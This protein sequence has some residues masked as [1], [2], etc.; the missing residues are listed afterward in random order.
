M[1]YFYSKYLIVAVLFCTAVGC[2]ITSHS[3]NYQTLLDSKLSPEELGKAKFIYGD[4]GGLYPHTLKTNG[5]VYKITFLALAALD[6]N[7]QSITSQS[8]FSKYGFIFPKKI[9][10]WENG[11]VMKDKP[12]GIVFGKISGTLLLHGKY[13]IE[14]ADFG[15][16]SC[17]GGLTYDKEGNRTDEFVLGMPNTSLDLDK[18]ANNVFE[19]YK[20]I[21]KW[22]DEKFKK[23][24]TE[25]FPDI[26]KQE[27]TGLKIVFKSIKP[28]VEKI[29]RTRGKVAP[30]KIGGPGMMNG[31]GAIKRG[32]G[33]LDNSVYH[34]DEVALVSAPMIQDRS[35]RSNFTIAANY[36]MKNE[37]FF[38]EITA[39]DTNQKH[40][41][42][43]S[44]II[45]AF[46]IATMGFTPKMAEK[47]IPDAK[48]VMI[49]I[50]K[51]KAPDFPGAID[52]TKS[53]EGR[54]V[55]QH[56]CESCHGKYE[57][58]PVRN[59]LS[60]YPNMFIPLTA[61][62]TDSV[63]ASII[64][65]NNTK[66]IEKTVMGKYFAVRANKGYVAPILAGLWATAPYL[67]NGSVPTLWHFMHP[68]LRPGKFYVGGHQLDYEKVGIKGKMKEGVY[69]YPE[70]FKPWC[71]YEIY[72]TKMPGLSNSG[73]YEQ[74]EKITEKEK[75]CLLEFLKT[76]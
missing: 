56:N 67:H 58:S 64:T 49:F 71:D 2:I 19:G 70:G 54:F 73:H 28:E 61:I 41:E 15:C 55:F 18:F 63:R 45:A 76:L 26:S 46:T 43:M 33:L 75:D 3:D 5:M 12:I 24:I 23:R 37:D 7:N 13:E 39:N 4:M 27:L 72:D 10:N 1:K 16:G 66:E 40:D 42:D 17:H 47:A 11:K 31:I 74:F 65:T 35:F 8:L 48:D 59:K 69:K 30:Y 57:G 51:I 21:V 62:K 32:L 52:T 9:W 22:G 38:Y 29:I 6:S 50:S 53:E 25:L 14:T 60:S 34:K 68:E 20:I 36:G 44:T